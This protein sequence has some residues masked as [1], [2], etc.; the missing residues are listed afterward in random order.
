MSLE[1]TKV[2]VTGGCGFIGT[3]LVEALADADYDVVVVDNGP[4]MD[5]WVSAFIEGRKVK[6]YRFDIVKP[7]ALGEV[8]WREVLAD[9]DTIYHLAAIPSVSRSIEHPW[10]SHNANAT[11]TLEVLTAAKMFGVRRVVYASSSSV[12]GATPTQPKQEDMPTYPASPYAVSKLAGEHYCQVFQ[13]MGLETISLRYFNVY[14][15]GQDPESEYAAVIPKWVKA[16]IADE[17]VTIHGRGHQTRDF[18]YV[19]DV[20]RATMLAGESTAQGVFNIGTGRS[21]SLLELLEII[22]RAVGTEPLS[23]FVAPRPGDVRDS[24]ADTTLAGERLGF[25]AAWKLEQGIGEMVT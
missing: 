3:H 16:V 25:K 12:Y 6:F 5:A 15:P 7:A 2:L 21:H 10:A 13:S 23:E 1:K 20:V 22:G 17:R 8:S 11:G 9:I 14:G 4:T 19:K 24:L 18:T